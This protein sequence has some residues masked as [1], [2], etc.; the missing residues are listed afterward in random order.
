MIDLNLLD[1]KQK[2]AYYALKQMPAGDTL[3]HAAIKL[4]MKENNME[5]FL[6]M[7]S[8]LKSQAM[9]NLKM[10]QDILGAAAFN[11]IMQVNHFDTLFD[12]NYKMIKSNIESDR[13]RGMLDLET[14]YQ[15]I[16]ERIKPFDEAKAS[17]LKGLIQVRSVEPMLERYPVA[18]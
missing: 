7:L 11:A 15:M 9:D 4:R 14:C 13:L 16:D 18:E 1:T 8:D 10:M 3:F 5:R 6:S 2:A 17:E 12:R